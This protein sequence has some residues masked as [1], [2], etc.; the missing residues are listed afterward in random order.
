MTEKKVK[1]DIVILGHIAKDIITIDDSSKEAIGGAVYY[2]GIAGSH[3]GLKITVI[4]RLRKEDYP[5]LEEFKKYGIH[6]FAYPSQE[7]SG[8]RNIYNSENMET[9]IC[10]PLG[11]AGLFSKEEIPEIK[12]KYFVLGPITAGEIDLELFN[13][14]AE[15][16]R[17]K[18]CIDIQGFVR[19]RDH[20]EDK[21]YFS[22][23]AE[24]EKQAILPKVNILKVDHAELKAL[25]NIEDIREGATLLSEYGINEILIS[26][27]QGISVHVENQ[28]FF[29]PWR[30]KEIRGRTGRGDTAFISYIGSR[31][32]KDPADALTFSAALT[33]L[34][35]E[36]PG[37]F[38]LPL[39][40]VEELIK[41][42]Y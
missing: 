32:S 22:N 9:R 16:Y 4:T 27:K 15:K 1:T 33:S 17:G 25:T 10:K 24:E 40:Q 35:L 41:K 23:L 6:Y 29:F 18:I 36:H 42:E 8:L 37:P 13:Y 19:I 21:V 14:L 31:I 28:L 30:Y 3:M 20:R 2:G 11:F 38:V 7:T 5:I 34:K 39:H 12:P 26:H